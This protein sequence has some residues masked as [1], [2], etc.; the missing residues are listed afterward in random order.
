VQT[1][2][3][4]DDLS[5]CFA[6]SAAAQIRNFSLICRAMGDL[7]RSAEY[8]HSQLLTQRLRICRQT[9]VVLASE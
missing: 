5:C 7:V 4:A 6:E 1:T 8:K 9:E 3:H 2:V